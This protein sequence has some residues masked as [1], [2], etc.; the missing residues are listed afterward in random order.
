M[1]GSWDLNHQ[2]G[3]A[4]PPPRAAA[5]RLA[6]LVLEKKRAPATAAS[7]GAM[8]LHIMHAVNRLELHYTDPGTAA[9]SRRP[10]SSVPPPQPHV[11][12]RQGLAS[13]GAKLTVSQS[14]PK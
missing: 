9:P 4:T 12:S 7:C 6:D 3:G 1:D 13:I 2:R 8:L 11:R 10:V 5:A 14:L